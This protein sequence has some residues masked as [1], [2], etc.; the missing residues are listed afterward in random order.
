MN[1]ENPATPAQ[2]ATPGSDTKVVTT[3][4]TPAA[5]VVVAPEGKVT[6]GTGQY[7]QLVRDAARGRSAARRAEIRS[8]AAPV[9]IPGDS[10]AT[11]ALQEANE[12]AEQAEIRAMQTEVRIGV[13]DILDKEEFK[14]LPKSTKDLI[15]QNPAALSQ[16]STLEE[17][18]LDIEDWCREQVGQIT[19]AAGAPA[20]GAQPAGHQTPPVV[21][22]GSPAPSKAV[23]LEDTSKLH[24]S[25]RSVASIRNA[26]RSQKKGN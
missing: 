6:L 21:S 20:T 19:P 23:E 24:G 8:A 18:L 9:V 14:I 11:Q 7:A 3:P 13:R 10:V 25:A 22:G 2:A 1:K 4:S 16:A 17:S 26:F 15:L 5:S 12:R